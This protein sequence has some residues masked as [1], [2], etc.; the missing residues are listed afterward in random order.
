MSIDDQPLPRSYVRSLLCGQV[1]LDLYRPFPRLSHGRVK[2]VEDLL[3][4]IR[5]DG[6]HDSGIASLRAWKLLGQAESWPNLLLSRVIR[7]VGATHPSAALS[8]ISHICLGT[9]LIQVWGT[10]AQVRLLE[11]AE[12]LVLAFALTEASPGSDVSRIQTYA[13]PQGDGYC[14]S[15]VKH[16]VTNGRD[17]THFIVLARTIAPRAGD[18]PKLTA[19]LVPRSENIEVIPVASDVL[20]G[21]GVSEIRFRNVQLSKDDVLGKVG[22]GF[23]VVMHG[24]SE[25][26]LQVGAALSGASIHTMNSTIERLKAR[27]AFGRE[28]ARFPSVQSTVAVMMAETLATE[29]LVYAVAGPIDRP[30]DLD[31]VERAV[32]RLAASRSAARVLDAAR[33]LHGAAAFSGNMSAFRHWADTRALSLLDGSDHALQSYIVLEGTRKVRDRLQTMAHGHGPLVR[34]DAAA[35]HLIDKA[36]ARMHRVKTSAQE[37]LELD[38]LHDLAGSLSRAVD[39]AIVKHGVEFVEKQHVHRRLAVASADLSAWGAL[40]ARVANERELMGEVGSRRMVDVAQVWVT[41]AERRIRAELRR[42]EDNDDPLRDE[43]ARR[44]Y[45]DDG[46]PFDII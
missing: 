29:S 10:E 14:L 34:M 3:D 8:A 22:K 39:R 28:I 18:K 41:A 6:P 31:P 7:Q 32:V 26:R 2:Q 4:S 33:E 30:L 43:V 11:H 21:A 19:F 16:W 9:R 40:S 37:G 13:E 24:L 23:R 17:A 46:Y 27:R 44:A 36:S 12:D 38:K 20:G 45:G 42:V 35:S 1:D 25:A 5:K 15:G